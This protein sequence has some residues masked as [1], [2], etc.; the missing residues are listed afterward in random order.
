MSCLRYLSLFVYCGVQHILCC[1]FH[2]FVLCLV[3]PIL[4]VSLDCPYLIAPSVF[5]SVCILSCIIALHGYCS[6]ILSNS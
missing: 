2:L 3:C 1:V 6:P 4:P 5:F